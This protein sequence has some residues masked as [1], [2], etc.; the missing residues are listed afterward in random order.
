MFTG[1]SVCGTRG[2]QSPAPPIIVCLFRFP[3][4][5]YIGLNS[6]SACFASGVPIF[7]KAK[8]TWY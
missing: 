1:I 5:R 4:L 3:V 2:F 8:A 6:A 7:S